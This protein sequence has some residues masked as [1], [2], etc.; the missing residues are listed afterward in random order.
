MGRPANQYPLGSDTSTTHHQA[1]RKISHRGKHPGPSTRVVSPP[2]PSR[3]PPGSPSIATHPPHNALIGPPHWQSTAIHPTS[4]E[5]H[6]NVSPHPEAQPRLTSTELAIS[7]K[8]DS[9]PFRPP[10]RLPIPRCV[11][12]PQLA[13]PAHGGQ[14]TLQRTQSIFRPLTSQLLFGHND[15][16]PH[17]A[18]SFPRLPHRL[19]PRATRIPQGRCSAC[20]PL[21]SPCPTRRTRSWT[22][23]HPSSP[24]C[25]VGSWPYAWRCS[26][27]RIPLAGLLLALAVEVAR[28]SQSERHLAHLG[29]LRDTFA[30]NSCV[31]S[32]G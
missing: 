27:G 22:D 12:R 1:R 11:E 29:Q 32:R 25:R 17:E 10:K 28:V 15:V 20:R 31:F 24:R 5:P 4:R 19:P 21:S 2:G 9:Q 3:L 13:P 18:C 6:R 7:A 30:R 16:V 23:V 8:P 14:A 26:L